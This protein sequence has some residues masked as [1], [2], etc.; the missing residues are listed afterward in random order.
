MALSTLR[1]WQISLFAGLLFL[2]VSL[3][4]TYEL[5]GRALSYLGLSFDKTHHLLLHVGVFILLTK[6]SMSWRL[7]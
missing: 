2:L 7:F 4:K 6:W 5:T 3:P 1:E